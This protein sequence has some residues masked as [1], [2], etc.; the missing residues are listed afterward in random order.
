MSTQGLW[1]RVQAWATPRHVIYSALIFV[2]GSLIGV[3]L[4]TFGYA[5]GA[6]YLS[7]DPKT[8]INCHAMGGQYEGWL[9]GS[10]ANVAT[11]NDCHSP[12][13]NVVHKYLVKGENGFRHA[14]M[15]TTQRYPENIEIRDYNRQVAE[16]SCLYC[17][18]GL[19]DQIHITRPS[20]D[21]IS[22]LRCHQ[23]VGHL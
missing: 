8:C 4:F 13:D 1:A 11:C 16:D 22:C 14:L 9:K 23:D 17:H 7:N 3:G 2:L 6:S 21:Q 18:Q 19:V 15:F 12:H 5:N 20:G 10:H